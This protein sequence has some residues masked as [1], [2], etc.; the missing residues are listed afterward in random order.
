[1]LFV[2]R[3]CVHDT[4]IADDVP[5]HVGERVIV[6]TASANRDEQLFNDADDFRID[7]DNA[8]R[9]TSCLV[10]GRRSGHDPLGGIAVVR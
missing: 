9:L 3:G 7:R 8:D 4:T 1:M 10:L 2:P 6:G 5:V